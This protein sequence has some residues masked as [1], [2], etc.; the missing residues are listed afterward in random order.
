MDKVLLERQGKIVYVTLNN[1]PFNIMDQY[2]YGEIRAAFEE[3]ET[4]DNICAVVLKSGCKHFCAGGR[5]EE[6]QECN[7]DENT[8]VIAGAAA[9]CMA[10]IYNCKVPVI[11]SVHGKCIGAG[12]AMTFSAD[13]MVCSDDATFSLAEIKAGYIGASE[14]LEMGMPRRLARYYIFTGDTMTAQQLQQWGTAYK[15][16]PR[17]QLEEET[18]LIAEKIAEQSPLALN[19]FKEAMNINDNEQ[20]VEKYM[21]ESKY[22]TKYNSSEDCK[23]TFKAFKEKRKPNYLGV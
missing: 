19:Y 6:I 2:Y 14:F 1:P 23:E 4:M 9:S 22:T 3:I 11:A 16:V 20:L 15:V 17:N 21:L 5:L 8:A 13:I 10:A 18:R 12:I 7:S